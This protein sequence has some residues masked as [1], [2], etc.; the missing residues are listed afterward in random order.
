MVSTMVLQRY[1]LYSTI[2]DVISPPVV[3]LDGPPDHLSNGIVIVSLYDTDMRSKAFFPS[4][5]NG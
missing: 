5:V 1:Y 3:T 4:S 2:I